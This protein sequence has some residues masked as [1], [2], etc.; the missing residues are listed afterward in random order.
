MKTADELRE[1][2][3]K[4]FEAQKHIRIPSSSL[5]PSHEDS[6]VL[7]T[8][9]GMQQLKPYFL[10]KKDPEKDFGGRALASVQK[11]FRTADID[12]VGDESH[13]TFFEMLGN[14]SIG[15]YFKKETI[16]Y[17]WEFMT[18]TLK[19]PKDRLWATIF[20]GD[21]HAPRDE[22]AEK[23][24]RNYLPKERILAFGREENWWG[25]TGDSGPCGPSSELHVDLTGK[26]VDGKKED[27][28]NSDTG[29]FLE[30]WNLV[31]TEYHK[32]T[33]G[34]F[35]ELSEKHID[36]GMGLERIAMVMQGKD[37]VFGTELYAKL[38]EAIH[39][40]ERFEGLSPREKEISER[41]I[42]DHLKGVV[43]L[44]A[45]GVEFSNKDQG[46]ILRR[47]F[48]RALDQC[49]H[50]EETIP[51]VFRAVAETYSAQYPELLEKM[52]AIR[53]LAETELN[54]YAKV[55]NTDI[56]RV[57]VKLS[58]VKPGKAEAEKTPSARTLTPAEAFQ[59]YTTYGFSPER[60][61][62]KG[63]TF[64][65]PAFDKLVS[66]HKEVSKRGQEKKFGGHGLHGGFSLEGKSADD[67][68]R[69]TRQHTAT[70]LLHQALRTVLGDHVKQ[71]GS[72]I[73]PERL[74]FDFTHPKKLTDDERKAVEDLVNQK[75]RE[76]LKVTCEEMD[77]KEAIASG[78]LSF[79]KEKYSER[80]T[81]YSIGDFSKELC[82]GPHVEHTSQIGKFTILSEKSSAAGIRRIK[83]RV[84]DTE[85]SIL[86]K[87]SGS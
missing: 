32:S 69:I 79:F 46:Y 19:F 82:G 31:F 52:P 72:D 87:T 55:L 76:D 39:A 49:D 23:E 50:A 44:I 43:F 22:V 77:T 5:V 13:L 34:A 47:I 20:A 48:R 73:N 4:Y 7:L 29:R 58:K 27:G 36:T 45:D 40:H 1:D 41:I 67:V 10:G 53:A 78:A 38:H 57:L 14:F 56:E 33:S 2:F 17:A 3:L 81:V 86:P 9:A 24:W 62:R 8:T 21:E 64:D 66:A 37:S 28:P 61:V 68:W 54:A 30:V 71:N 51:A 25:P 74:R 63:Y 60:L 70:H 85:S 6:S 11:C 35:T 16:R 59:L 80:S 84:E 12:A 15:G 75:I 26:P 65:R 18:T 83:A 42:M